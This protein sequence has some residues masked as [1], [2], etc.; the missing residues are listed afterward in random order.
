MLEPPGTGGL[1]R[2]P[3]ADPADRRARRPGHRDPAR[4]AHSHGGALTMAGAEP[5]P[6]WEREF[7]EKQAAGAERAAVPE[8]CEHAWA[9]KHE[10][11]RLLYWIRQCML[12]REVDWDDLDAEISKRHA[13]MSGQCPATTRHTPR[14]SVEARGLHGRFTRGH[15][16]D[17]CAN[18]GFSKDAV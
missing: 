7:L 4:R 11:G 10:P 18:A 9:S 17:H 15:A 5:L 14:G 12:C 3:L 8:K 2:A 6:D 13:G 16:G 1:S